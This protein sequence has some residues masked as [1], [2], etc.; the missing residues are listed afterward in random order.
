M[1]RLSGTSPSRVMSSR[2]GQP[3][4]KFVMIYDG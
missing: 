2:Q 3:E 4:R 1:R